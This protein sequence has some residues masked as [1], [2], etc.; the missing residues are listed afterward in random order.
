[1]ETPYTVKPNFIHRV[2]FTVLCVSIILLFYF[3]DN[4]EFWNSD[5]YILRYILVGIY[6]I[7]V[8]NTFGL[9]IRKINFT[10]ENIIYRNSF[11]FTKIK[12]YKDIVKVVGEAEN[13][14][15]KFSDESL[16]K[17]WVSEGNINKILR[18]IKKKREELRS[19][20]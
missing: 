3:F 13:I 6:I 4:G 16:I 15:I 17:V 5:D 19:E 12:K 1:M 11:G 8:F 10:D 14:S 9:F 2:L 20:F 7:F 18:I